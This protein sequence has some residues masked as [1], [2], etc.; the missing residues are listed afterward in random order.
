[1]KNKQTLINTIKTNR[2]KTKELEHSIHQQE[3]KL[4]EM[5]SEELTNLGISNEYRENDKHLNISFEGKFRMNR[6]IRI[7][8]YGGNFQLNI[9]HIINEMNSFIQI[10]V[11]KILSKF[12]NELTD[13]QLDYLAMYNC[14]E[15][16]EEY[17]LNQIVN[18]ELFNTLK[19]EG[20]LK[21]NG[22]TYKMT[23]SQKGRYLITFPG[24]YTKSL[25]KTSILDKLYHEA[26][27]VSRELVK[28]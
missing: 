22:R 7:S 26:R 8:F 3:I 5:V 20:F 2:I 19:T 23:E 14:R 10:Q 18:E 28:I 11:F 15:R 27:E 9:P 16:N 21:V 17:E 25:F 13:L 24:D 12:E 1:M 6:D 4:I